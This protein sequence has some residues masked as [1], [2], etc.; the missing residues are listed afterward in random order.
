MKLGELLAQIAL[1]RQQGVTDD[2][3]VIIEGYIEDRNSFIQ[4]YVV[5]ATGEARCEEEH[6]P[7]GLYL[8]VDEV[9]IDD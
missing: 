8:T 1:A 9:T 7:V 6:A 5:K 4:G 3:P 2:S